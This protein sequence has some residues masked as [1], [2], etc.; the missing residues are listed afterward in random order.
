MRELSPGLR[1]ATRYRDKF[2]AAGWEFGASIPDVRRCPAGPK[3]AKPNPGIAAQNVGLMK[4]RGEFAG[5]CQA[6][7]CVFC[8]H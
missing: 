5:Y 3:D 7:S 8:S 4:N 6:H 1:L 2:Q